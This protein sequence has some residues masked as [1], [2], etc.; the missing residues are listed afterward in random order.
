[1]TIKID[2]YLMSSKDFSLHIKQEF[3]FVGGCLFNV[4]YLNVLKIANAEHICQSLLLGS[5]LMVDFL[6]YE[7]TND[8]Q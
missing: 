5:T 3:F 8:W 4:T 2:L 1:M 6:F 7:S